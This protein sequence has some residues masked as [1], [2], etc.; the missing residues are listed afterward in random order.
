MGRHVTGAL[1][2]IL[3]RALLDATLQRFS[4]DGG[5]RRDGERCRGE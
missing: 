3:R 2:W 1:T 5:H 4:G